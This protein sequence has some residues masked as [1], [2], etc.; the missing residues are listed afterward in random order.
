MKK[1][2]L[3]LAFGAVVALM[4]TTAMLTAESRVTEQPAAG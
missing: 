2:Y 4:M 1:Q 3:I